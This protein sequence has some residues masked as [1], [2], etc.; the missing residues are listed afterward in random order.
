MVAVIVGGL[1][2]LAVMLFILPRLNEL[3][4]ISVRAGR[5]LVIRGR[6]PKAL[7]RDME[8]VITRAGVSQ[9]TIRAV[10]T[11]SH[12]RLIVTGADE[13]VIQRL[14]NTFGIH[15]ISKFRKRTPPEEERNFG[16]RLGWTW[17]AWLLNSRRR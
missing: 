13:F 2:F 17:L 6:V 16:Q 12:A 3:F 15:P 11:E 10:K 9:A 1:I 14:R 7:L 5:L 8:D 4:L